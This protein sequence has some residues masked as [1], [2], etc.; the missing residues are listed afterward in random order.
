[1]AHIRNMQ[2]HDRMKGLYIRAERNLGNEAGY[3][4]STVVF[5]EIKS[6]G[7]FNSLWI[8]LFPLSKQRIYQQPSCIPSA[9]FTPTTVLIFW[10]ENHNEHEW[11]ERRD[12]VVRGLLAF[13]QRHLN[14]LRIEEELDQFFRENT[15]LFLPSPQVD[16]GLWSGH[17]AGGIRGGDARGHGARLAGGHRD[18]GS[19]HGRSRSPAQSRHDS[20]RRHRSR[21]RRLD[22][23]KS[24]DFG[25]ARRSFRQG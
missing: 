11:Q 8:V 4:R 1:M 16:N 17:G 19:R 12:A 20:S 18:R 5:V 2:K 25:L 10:A 15:G 9:R 13:A 3:P 6:P 23:V 7:K 22:V 14:R 24:E 21:E